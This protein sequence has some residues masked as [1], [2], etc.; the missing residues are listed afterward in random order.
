MNKY[1]VLSVLLSVSVCSLGQNAKSLADCRALALE[2]NK[3]RKVV[4][5]QVELAKKDHRSAIANLTPKIYLDAN[6]ILYSKTPQNDQ[7]DTY[8]PTYKPD[9]SEDGQFKGLKPNVFLNPKTKKPVQGPSG[10]PLFNEYA[11]FPSSK[12]AVDFTGTTW[13]QAVLEQPIY[14]GG[15]ILAGISIT[16]KLV[17]ISQERMRLNEAQLLLEVDKAYYQ[18]LSI[19]EK[20]KLANLYLEMLETVKQTVERSY[21]VEL[22]NRNDLLK[23]Q[24][25]LNAAKLALQEANHG[26]ELSKM[27]LCRIMNMPYEESFNIADSSVVSLGDIQYF[28]HSL[29]ARAEYK[30]LQKSMEVF[31]EKVSLARADFLPQLGLRASYGYYSGLQFNGGNVS[32][33]TYSAI[34][35]LR[36]PVFQ[37]FE[38]F[39]KVDRAKVEQHIEQLKMDD[40]AA[41][42]RLEIRRNEFSLKDALTK[43]EMSMLSLDQASE[44]MRI[45]EDNYKQGRE[46]ISD[47][48]KAKAEW[49]K[50]YAQLIDAKIAVKINQTAYLKSLG[51]LN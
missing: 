37:W 26:L 49:Q 29:E 3:A 24:V 43:Y 32:G 44:N 10:Q 19:K 23:A 42:M 50:I 16:D 20:H 36:V 22:V 38:R 40:K 25:A 13:A 11:F 27:N 15:K 8:L 31:D 47:M 5:Q 17:D 12:L 2:N 39:N 34:V 18:L 35:N 14:M 7:E 30:M 4:K 48:L 51:R 6:A 33:D 45:S 28:E 46:T 41:L 21:T 9:F 1:I